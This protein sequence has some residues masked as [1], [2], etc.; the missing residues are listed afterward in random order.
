MR[1]QR[2]LDAARLRL[3]RDRPRRPVRADRDGARVGGNG[4]A[5]AHD[6]FSAARATTS[7]I[8]WASSRPI[9][10]PSSSAAGESA[11]LPRQ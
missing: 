1:D 7:S 3:P 8:A 2:H 5:R 4:D 6:R 9:G 11:Q 10:S